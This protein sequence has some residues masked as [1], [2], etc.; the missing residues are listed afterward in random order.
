VDALGALIPQV[1]VAG[2]EEKL[3]VLLEGTMSAHE[4]IPF[5]WTSLEVERHRVFVKMDASNPS[6][7][8]MADEWL[9]KNDPQAGKRE[10]EEQEETSKLF[11][12]GPKKP[13]SETVH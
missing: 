13:G 3:R 9:A 1:L 6:L 5:D 4:N 10:K 8:Q 7:D 11:V 2:N 12:T